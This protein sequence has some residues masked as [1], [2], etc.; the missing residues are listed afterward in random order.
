MAEQRYVSDELT[1]FVGRGM[2]LEEQFRL[3]VKILRA[4]WLCA[5][6]S[7]QF[8]SGVIMSTTSATPLT[9]NEAVRVRAVCFCDIPVAG[10]EIHMQKYSR[11]GLAFSKRY[12]ISRGASPVFYVASTAAPASHPGPR[13]RG[14]AFERLRRELATF[15]HEF[16]ELAFSREP[17]S[18]GKYRLTFEHAPDGTPELLRRAGKLN[19]LISEL[20]AVVF[21]HM[22]FFDGELP[23]SHEANFYME[24]EWRKVGGLA[25]ELSDLRRII[26]PRAFTG[27]FNE[28][29]PACA[30]KLHPV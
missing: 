28:A 6:Y 3:L 5:S 30:E 27:R 21:A 20:D 23:E 22:K 12:M 26:A 19:A 10:L 24:R 13:S 29:F 9:T 2:E 25:F 7:N 8:G 4:Q 14:E 17:Q 18:D 11:F 15:G 16:N 1:H